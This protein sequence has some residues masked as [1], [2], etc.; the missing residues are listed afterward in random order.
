[1]PTVLEVHTQ[2]QKQYLAASHLFLELSVLCVLG[3]VVA[4][5]FV[6]YCQSVSL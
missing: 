5:L 2:H 6:A 1:M 3:T 4:K